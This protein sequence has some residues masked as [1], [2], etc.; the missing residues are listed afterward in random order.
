MS[1][2]TEEAKALRDRISRYPGLTREELD[3]ILKIE[4]EFVQLLDRILHL[5]PLDAQTHEAIARLEE[6]RTWA[7]LSVKRGQ[8]G[9]YSRSDY[10][11]PNNPPLSNSKLVEYSFEMV[12]YT[13]DMVLNTIL[14]RCMPN[15]EMDLSIARLDEAKVALNLIAPRVMV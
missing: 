9:G 11:P 6:S 1:D 8:Q 4:F 5:Y 2:L 10:S 12:E 13:F 14:S 3:K 7:G 15:R